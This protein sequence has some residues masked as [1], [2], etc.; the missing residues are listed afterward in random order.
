MAAQPTRITGEADLPA[1][2]G[3][4]GRVVRLLMVAAG[5]WFTYHVWVRRGFIFT[6]FDLPLTAVVVFS[7]HQIAGL[8]GKAKLADT[9]LAVAAASTAG[10]AIAWTGSLWAPPLSWLVWG[11]GNLLLAVITV[12]LLVSVFIGT[13]GCE[14]GVLAE[15]TP[16]LRR[17]VRRAEVMFCLVGLHKLD[18]WEARRARTE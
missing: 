7:T 8:F 18:A 10:L 14:L 6:H 3:P 13:P 16:R 5:V 4:L 9:A 2:T 17:Q 11:M 12:T 1:R 15:V